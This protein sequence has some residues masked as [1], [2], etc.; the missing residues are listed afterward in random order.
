MKLEIY[1]GLPGTTPHAK[2]QVATSTGQFDAQVFFLQH[3]RP[4]HLL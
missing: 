2:F 4:E 1:N 3:V